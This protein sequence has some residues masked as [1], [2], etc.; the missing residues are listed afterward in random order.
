[1]MSIG[2]CFCG[3]RT[4]SALQIAMGT[5]DIVLEGNR[6]RLEPLAMRH[7]DGLVAASA[8]D[9]SLYRWSP[10]PQGQAEA[11]RY[12]ETALAR[13]RPGLLCHLQS[14]D[15]KMIR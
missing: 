5:K 1:M 3:S 11:A 4:K 6:V 8:A 13:K 14:S 10:V 15:G 9:P 7:M 2:L 12:I